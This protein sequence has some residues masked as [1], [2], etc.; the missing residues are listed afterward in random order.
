MF[1]HRS[2]LALIS[3]TL[4]YSSVAQCEYDKEYYYSQNRLNHTSRLIARLGLIDKLEDRS[5]LNVLPSVGITATPNGVGPLIS[6]NPSSLLINKNRKAQ[7]KYREFEAI[8]IS[9]AAIKEDSIKI[10][11]IFLSIDRAQNLIKYDNEMDSLKIKIDYL[12]NLNPLDSLLLKP[13]DFLNH[14]ILKTQKQKNNTSLLYSIKEFCLEL[15][16]FI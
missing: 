12:K 10:L 8:L 1:S 2:I 11:K 7:L 15:L 4:T 5:K 14:E 3:L 16:G 13:S 6:W 9:E